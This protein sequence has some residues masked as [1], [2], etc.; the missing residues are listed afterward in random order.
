MISIICKP[1]ISGVF[2]LPVSGGRRCAGRLKAVTVCLAALACDAAV[3]I[4]MGTAVCRRL[5]AIYSRPLVEELI[6]PVDAW[7]AAAALVGIEAFCL[8]CIT[9]IALPDIV[10]RQADFPG[11]EIEQ[12]RPCDLHPDLRSDHQRP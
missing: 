6:Y 3:I 4:T 11:I 12:G 7:L 1:R 8:P 9:W 5:L 10:A 2:N